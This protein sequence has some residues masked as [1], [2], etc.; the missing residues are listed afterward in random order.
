[1]VRGAMWAIGL[2]RQEKDLMTVTLT[3][4]HYH[5]VCVHEYIHACGYG[6]ICDKDK[7]QEEKNFSCAKQ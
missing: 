2:Y 7:T 3:G 4:N 1:M 6:H 5:Y